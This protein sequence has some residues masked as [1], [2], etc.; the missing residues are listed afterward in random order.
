MDQ[1]Q[2]APPPPPFEYLVHPRE[3]TWVKNPVGDA[4]SRNAVMVA[5]QVGTI[6]PGH[7]WYDAVI[8]AFGGPSE[9]DAPDA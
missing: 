7:A 9:G 1:I 3:E 4:P 6:Q 8:A 2:N 5:M